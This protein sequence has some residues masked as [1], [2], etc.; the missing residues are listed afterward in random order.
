[1][2]KGLIDTAE[3]TVAG[4]EN[5]GSKASVNLAHYLQIPRRSCLALSEV[6]SSRE[7][8]PLPDPADE[9]YFPVLIDNVNHE[10]V[11]Q[12]AQN[13]T[14]NA[15]LLAYA[16][17]SMVNSRL[18]VAQSYW[19]RSVECFGL[20][21]IIEK[22][23]AEYD[24]EKVKDTF[25]QIRKHI[26]AKLLR[27]RNRMG[28]AKLAIRLRKPEA[29]I[30]IPENYHV[31]ENFINDIMALDR[32]CDDCTREIFQ[33]TALGDAR[34]ETDEEFGYLLEQFQISGTGLP[35]EN[36]SRFI[37]V[38]SNNRCLHPMLPI[39][40][41]ALQQIAALLNVDTEIARQVIYLFR[42]AWICRLNKAK[43]FSDF[44][45]KSLVVVPQPEGD[46]AEQQTETVL[47]IVFDTLGGVMDT[48]PDLQFFTESFPDVPVKIAVNV[49]TL[50]APL[51]AV[52]ANAGSVEARLNF[53]TQYQIGWEYLKK[54]I[55][56]GFRLRNEN[57][58][59]NI[60]FSDELPVQDWEQLFGNVAYL[61]LK[62][63]KGGKLKDDAISSLKMT[64]ESVEKLLKSTIEDTT[65]EN[66]EKCTW[67]FNE[68]AKDDFIDTI[69]GIWGGK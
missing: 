3:A 51:Y 49:M 17:G 15:F 31:I 40:E 23:E 22:L 65:E 6:E 69:R 9:D 43:S 33:E 20:D 58:F 11:K 24:A 29:E 63:G 56:N 64:A 30:L 60:L 18:Q 55:A 44:T 5:G 53:I 37:E 8:R 26:N 50:P 54:F 66:L 2:M 21:A 45:F 57:P 61:K 14:G 34:Q 1:M 42:F 32:D 28:P 19:R 7:F 62:I 59:K 47:Q 52:F 25:W 13:I 12:L 36:I 46:G 67:L 35:E 4:S 41:T 39:P 48:H 68:T 27:D 16:R 38:L 10:L